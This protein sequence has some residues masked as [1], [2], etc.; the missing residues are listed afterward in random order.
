MKRARTCQ[1][2]KE[3]TVDWPRPRGALA[4][5]FV[6]AGAYAR[7]GYAVDERAAAGERG[8][9]FPRSQPHLYEQWVVNLKRDKW[10]PSP[11]SRLCSSHF[12]EACFDRSGSRT[13]LKSDAIPTLFSFPEHLQKK[14]PKRKPPKDRAPIPDLSTSDE[15]PSSPPAPPPEPSESAFDHSYAVLDTP[16]ILKRRLDMCT[17]VAEGVKKRLK[18]SQ[19][20]ERQLKTR[21]ASLSEIVDDLS[22]SNLFLK[23]LAKCWRS[24]LP[25]CH[26]KL[27][28]AS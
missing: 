4:A 11:G 7:S 10:K 19:Q 26:L 21:V 5:I 18:L 17:S 14:T 8:T 15:A 12:T 13:R 16:R 6:D 23:M 20:R 2:G 9:R 24:A 3:P 25:E 1:R 27:C 22:R 28:S